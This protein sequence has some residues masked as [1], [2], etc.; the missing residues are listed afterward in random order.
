MAARVD[1]TVD[2][3]KEIGGLETFQEW[4]LQVR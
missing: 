2:P 1:W 4:L 3:D